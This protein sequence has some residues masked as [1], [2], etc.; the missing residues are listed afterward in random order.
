MCGPLHLLAHWRRAYTKDSSPLR[1][2]AV[3]GLL[4]LAGCGHHE[5]GAPAPT[6]TASACPA[7]N[8]DD[9]YWY[10]AG[11]R[12][13]VPVGDCGYGYS[14]EERGSAP[15]FASRMLLDTTRREPC[16]ISR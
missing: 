14:A 3:A 5:A 13:P 4:V 7:G 10:P 2:L 9:V 1:A 15:R 8:P 12:C 11:A 16:V 6:T